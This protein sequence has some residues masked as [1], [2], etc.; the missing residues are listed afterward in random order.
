MIGRFLYFSGLIAWEDLIRALIW[1]RAQYPR[2][3]RLAVEWGLLSSD[4]VQ[5]ILNESRTRE[6]FGACALRMGYL[7]RFNIL[8]LLGKQR[9]LKKPLGE[10][11]VSQGLFNREKMDVLAEK[12]RLHNSGRL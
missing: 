8:A 10:Y 5:R 4:Q 9:L 7:T 12:Q 2:M 6:K 1:Q 3:G 11:F